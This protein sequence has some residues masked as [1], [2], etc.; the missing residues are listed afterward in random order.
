MRSMVD[1]PSVR[2]RLAAAPAALASA[3]HAAPQEPPAPGEWT[4]TEIVRHLIAVEEEVW[5]RRLGQLQTEEHP[6]WRW[7]EPGQWLGAPG[8]TLDDVLATYADLRAS[9][10]AILDD[11]GPDVWVRTG[12]HD[13]FGVLDVAGLMTVAA[14]HDDEHLASL[15][16]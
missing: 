6:R 15:R 2:D 3:A 16:R 5:H 10:L 8:A 13:T 7:V 4:P 11:L 9:T 14:D 1:H 12:T